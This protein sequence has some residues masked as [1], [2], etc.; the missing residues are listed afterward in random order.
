V[1]VFRFMIIDRDGQRIGR[2]ETS[3]TDWEAGD[4]FE[5]DGNLWRIVEMLP[6]VSTMVAYNGVWI[7]SPAQS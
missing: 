2:L 1:P 6:E 5:L 4:T 3:K 7:A